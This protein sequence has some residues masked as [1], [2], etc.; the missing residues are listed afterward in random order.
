MGRFL[1]ILNATSK[2]FATMPSPIANH[3]I[4][5]AGLLLSPSSA[6]TMAGIKNSN[7]ITGIF[8][9]WMEKI[10]KAYTNAFDA[11][12]LRILYTFHDEY[13][14]TDTIAAIRSEEHTS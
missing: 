12:L 8:N 10:C 5:T 14:I 1:A 6:K 2:R 3:P 11:A 7:T 4:V 9:L 13:P